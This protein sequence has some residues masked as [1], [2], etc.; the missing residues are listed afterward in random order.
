MSQKNHPNESGIIY[1][2][3][4]IKNIEYK[5]QDRFYIGLNPTFKKELYK[6][7]IKAAGT[8]RKLSKETNVSFTRLWDQL[9]RVPISIEVLSKISKYLIKNG[10]EKYNLSNIEKNIEYIK[11][12]GS[13]S[14][15]LYYPKFPINLKTKEGMRLISHIYHDGGIGKS[16][17]PKYTN[18]SLKEVQEFLEDAKKL[19]G[20]F[21]SNIIK[22]IN[23]RS[24]KEYYIINLP[25]V[26]GNILI[27]TGYKEGD[28][29]KDNPEVFEF[30]KKIEDKELIQEF[31]AKAFNDDGFVGTR[32]IG[33]GQASLIK[34]EEKP[35]NVLILNKLFLEKLGI[36]TFGPRLVERYKNRYGIVT[37]FNIT[38]CSKENIQKF[39]DNI[40]LIDHKNKKIE[41]YLVN[42]GL[43]SYKR[44]IYI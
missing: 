43:R 42:W 28:K 26:V 30:L 40:R 4:L 2:E 5:Y 39:Y 37:K 38:V 8:I 16:R 29:T 20:R 14:Q 9:T 23:I 6:N 3:D 22:D 27:S 44:G 19:F 21:N 11:S 18:Q 35:S 13:T 34:K 31:L 41:N 24:K 15:K 17:Q 1:L 25:T 10:Y 33:L 7:L 36:K 32:S 12:S